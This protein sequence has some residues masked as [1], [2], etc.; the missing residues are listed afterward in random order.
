M[1]RG[2]VR[3]ELVTYGGP[4]AYRGE[5]ACRVGRPA[6]VAQHSET[7]WYKARRLYEMWYKILNS[8][9]SPSF[10]PYTTRTRTDCTTCTHTDSGEGLEWPALGG[11][12]WSV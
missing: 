6:K 11:V 4:R 5:P 3:A 9:L 7:I 1:G 10:F 8:P 2:R 12:E